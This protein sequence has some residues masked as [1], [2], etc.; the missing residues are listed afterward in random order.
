MVCL[1]LRKFDR[2]V[3]GVLRRIPQPFKT[4]L[5]DTLVI[6]E[7]RPSRRLLRQM[8]IHADETLYGLYV[9]TPRTERGVEE[10][11][12][13]DKIFIFRKPLLEDF[14]EDE[15]ALREQIRLTVLHEIGH[16]FGLEEKDM[17]DPNC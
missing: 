2:V 14:G 7:D 3:R 9:G 15:Q 5:K 17:E 6:T 1:S 10:P 12:F 4:Y 16:Y 11:L 13:P 8:G